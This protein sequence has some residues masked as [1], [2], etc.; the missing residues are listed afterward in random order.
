[1]LKER[2]KTQMIEAMKA[3]DKRKKEILSLV[4]SEIAAAE[5]K[6]KGTLVTD[7][8]KKEAARLNIK[9]DDVVLSQETMDKINTEAVMT[10]SEEI[11]VIQKLIKSVNTTIQ[12]IEG[13]ESK[14]LELAKAKEELEIYSQF[15]PK[16][17]SEEEINQLID[18]ILSELGIEMP[19]K[20][21]QGKI[22]GKLMPL[23]K[24][25]ADGKLVSQLV[26][27]RF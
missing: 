2:I 3:K 25:K 8:R 14:Q 4:V 10:E 15:I 21:D 1:M 23:V 9:I 11:D 17:M 22:M 27:K 16:Q 18:N 7:A 26:L 5:S 24:G 12:S 13:I 6:K 19:V 20:S